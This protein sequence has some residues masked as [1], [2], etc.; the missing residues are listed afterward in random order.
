MSLH[1]ILCMF[2]DKVELK[3]VDLPKHRYQRG[4]VRLLTD[5]TICLSTID[6]ILYNTILHFL[7]LV[8]IN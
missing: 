8:I 3:H 1:V 4:N 7:S 2:S 5:C 6:S